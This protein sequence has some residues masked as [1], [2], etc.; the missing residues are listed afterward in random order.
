MNLEFKA[1]QLRSKVLL[2]ESMK[3]FTTTLSIIIFLSSHALAKSSHPS[4]PIEKKAA[5][6]LDR[7]SYGAK[8]GQIQELS[9]SGDD[10]IQKWIDAQMNPKTI[11][12][13]AVEAKVKK[14]PSFS[15]TVEQLTETYPKPKGKKS[16]KAQMGTEEMPKQ[17]LVELVS[18]KMIR[19]SESNR[20]LQEV[21]VDFWFNHFNVDFR[22]GMTKWLIT[23][24]ERDVIRP[25]VFGK[26]SDLL[27][28]VAHSPAMLFY[29]DNH[30]SVKVGLMPKTGPKK[31]QKGVKT[32]PKGINENYAREL[33]ELHTLGVNGGYTQKDVI[34]VARIMTGW[35]IDRSNGTFKFKSQTHDTGAKK[36]LGIAYPAGGGE[37]EGNRL[38]EFLA[39]QPAT[40]KFISRK[41]AVRFVSDDPPEALIEK[42]SKTFLATDGDLSAVYR[43]LF[44]SSEFLADAAKSSK[45]KTPFHL[46][47]SIV[48]ALDGEVDIGS[49]QDVKKI[50][51]ALGQMGQ[52]IYRCQPPTGFKDTAEF[53]VNPGALVTRINTALA[54]T[55]KRIPAITYDP[56]MFRAKLHE[57]KV[58]NSNQ[59]ALAYLDKWMLG[60]ELKPETIAKI[61]GELDQEPKILD[62]VD[63]KKKEMIAAS[64]HVS[65]LLGLLLGSPEFQRF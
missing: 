49:F 30:E 4:S 16:N 27:K 61:S 41:I 10:G 24:Y 47:V 9:K 2:L 58:S 53:W 7:L 13:S 39:K 51:V 22:K 38:L 17:M 59:N 40:A 25:N 14:L 6:I 57:N 64:V 26:F 65:K 20:Q 11:S 21:L 50:D 18:Q 33:M 8:P 28:A 36:V 19:A 23:S 48:R 37:E 60:S 43:E 29:L 15:M 44:K 52:P 62:E 1:F 54:I 32:T 3:H 12:D 46:I 55:N 63:A 45:I 34:A 56:G 5:H 31:K 42:L 35:S